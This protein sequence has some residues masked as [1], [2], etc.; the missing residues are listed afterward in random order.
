MIEVSAASFELA[1]TKLQYLN[2]NLNVCKPEGNLQVYV[3]CQNSI[4]AVLASCNCN[5][6]GTLGMCD[7]KYLMC[8]GK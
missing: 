5:L 8:D 7:P 1:C 3:Q 4:D 6:V 2:S